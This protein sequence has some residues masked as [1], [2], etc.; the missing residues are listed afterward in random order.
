MGICDNSAN[1]GY[2]RSVF[3]L[4]RA[5]A[6]IVSFYLLGVTVGA[7]A[8]PADISVR[9]SPRGLG[10][11]GET[12][13]NA[14]PKT[15]HLPAMTQQLIDCPGTDND[16]VANLTRGKVNVDV[17]SAT[18]TPLGQRLRTVVTT[19][20][21]GMLQAEVSRPLACTGS[22]TTC[23]VKFDIAKLTTSVTVEPIAESAGI[24]LLDPSVYVYLDEDDL[25]FDVSGCGLYGP[26]AD[27]ILS[28]VGSDVASAIKDQ[29]KETL[30][31][32]L[33]SSLGKQLSSVGS[34]GGKAEGLSFSGELKT[35][36]ADDKSLFFTSRLDVAATKHGTCVESSEHF[37]P[38][39]D[40]AEGIP[41]IGTEH[42]GLSIRRGTMREAVESAW[43]AG[44]LCLPSQKLGALG[45]PNQL[46]SIAANLIGLQ[47]GARISLF[48]S[49]RP[50]LELVAGDGTRIAI[51]LEN[52]KLVIDGTNGREDVS[53]EVVAN[54][55][56]DVELGV[57]IKS[58]QIVFK[59][60][61][62][63]LSELTLSASPPEAV[64]LGSPLLPFAVG[65]F[66][67]GLLKSRLTGMVIHPQVLRD[68]E[69]GPLGDI[70]VY[71][72]RAQTTSE[73]LQLYFDFFRNSR[74][75]YQAPNTV[76]I[77]EPVTWTREQS[78]TF[79]AASWDDQTPMP[80][81]RYS[82]R[83]D[84]GAWSSLKN[85]T[86]QT[87]F[88]DEGPHLVEVR[89]YDLRGNGDPSPAEAAFFVGMD[90]PFDGWGKDDSPAHGDDERFEGGCNM[91]VNGLP[92]TALGFGLVLCLIAI[93]GLG[94]LRPCKVSSKR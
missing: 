82:W 80:L 55:G 37:P 11:L 22:S 72:V 86:E 88:F 90:S 53:V 70:G 91:A 87:F 68:L 89:A 75:D 28:F 48:V 77:D 6:L 49:Q 25:S 40:E 46:P 60:T 85:L 18:L 43:S 14:I 21:S 4:K 36:S 61:K 71:L 54:V 64:D 83:V 20:L 15:L 94:R 56:I 5:P 33:L 16:T 67:E 30:R 29:I 47:P 52:I 93:L 84:N 31:Y 38:A 19:K 81:M 73:H 32:D 92:A 76:L 3:A 65:K 27:S 42:L 39:A 63:R 12:L 66:A 74:L 2:R 78:L 23:I 41:L 51:G 34:F 62:A 13:G 45:L 79:K 1:S 24:K 9:L 8:A 35:I 58:R 69:S 44:L 59:S 26:L 50:K 10:F 7:M 17:Q 57:D